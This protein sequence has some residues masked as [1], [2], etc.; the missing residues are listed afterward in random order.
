M[1][2]YT[3]TVEGQFI[4]RLLPQLDEYGL[5]QIGDSDSLFEK[6]TQADSSSDQVLQSLSGS[7]SGQSQHR[8]QSGHSQSVN[9]IESGQ[10]QPG[11]E[12]GQSQA[13]TESGQSQVSEG[14]STV[15]P[16]EDGATDHDSNTKSHSKS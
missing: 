3:L 8:L 1:C 9:D 2:V 13:G 5:F 10:S 7:E 15:K 12:S 11:T 16:P 6:Q 14:E 4:C